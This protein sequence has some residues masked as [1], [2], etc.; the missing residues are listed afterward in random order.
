MNNLYLTQNDDMTRIIIYLP[1]FDKV[2]DQ[3]IVNSQC[4]HKVQVHKSNACPL[5]NQVTKLF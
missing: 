2:I 5:K 4:T 1:E 3:Y